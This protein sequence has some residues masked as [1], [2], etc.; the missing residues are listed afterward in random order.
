MTKYAKKENGPPVMTLKYRESKLGNHLDL[1]H[2]YN[3]K[4]KKVVMLS[5]PALRADFYK[6]GDTWK[7]V[8]VTY[9]MMQDKGKYY[10][11]NSE[12][13][14]RRRESKDIDN[15][16]QF[17]FSLYS[18]DILELEKQDGIKEKIKFKGVNN[19]GRN[20]L[21]VDFIDKLN[22]NYIEGIKK[23]Q[24]ILKENPDININRFYE[25]VYGIIGEK[26]ELLKCK[27]FI[28]KYPVSSKQ[29]F[30]TIGRD[31]QF[32]RKIYTDA[33]GKE[34][35]SKEKFVSRIYK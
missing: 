16:Y 26:I 29:K 4:D 19:D 17:M 12:E 5:I 21:E 11:L 15:G 24:E 23:L 25:K 22:G 32:L 34:Y 8:T 2:K 33:L 1:S 9:L 7:F 28:Q 6:K 14:E 10:D 3:V 20:T 35:D 13:Y 31:I 30:L 18:G 27:E